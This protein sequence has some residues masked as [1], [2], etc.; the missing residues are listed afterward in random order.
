MEGSTQ[1]LVY[2]KSS[3]KVIMIMINPYNIHIFELDFLRIV[4]NELILF[5]SI[6][7]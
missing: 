3:M 2:S 4:L 1:G 6:K 5:L 7:M